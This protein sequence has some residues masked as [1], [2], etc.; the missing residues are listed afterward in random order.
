MAYEFKKLSDV[1]AIEAMSDSTNV[2]VEENGE[3]VKLA[4]EKISPSDVVKTVNGQE[5][6]EYGN[7][8]I[9][10][11]ESNEPTIYYCDLSNDENQY[12]ILYYD[13]NYAEGEGGPVAREN[14]D[15]I[16]VGKDMIEYYCDGL[17]C[18][19]IILGKN[20]DEYTFW[21]IDFLGGI[22][23]VQLSDQA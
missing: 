13:N 19:S 14:F 21:F 12:K 4:A 17:L 1:N 9:D 2:L 22:N 16:I 5:P 3:I 6:D 18:Q 20:I 8:Y 10:I 7:V 23:I 11:S 15:F